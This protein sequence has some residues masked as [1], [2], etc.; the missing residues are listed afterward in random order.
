MVRRV[1]QPIDTFVVVATLKTIGLRTKTTVADLHTELSGM[2]P[3][4]ALEALRTLLTDVR[5][6]GIDRDA[7]KRFVPLFS[8]VVQRALTRWLDDD[9]DVA[10]VALCEQYLSIA[11]LHA[12][13]GSSADG[14]TDVDVCLRKIAAGS[15]IVGDFD[16][17]DSD[18]MLL[19][20]SRLAMFAAHEGWGDQIA[21]GQALVPLLCASHRR[22]KFDQL[23]RAETGIGLEEA[24]SMTALFATLGGRNIV[25]N[26]LVSWPTKPEA[27]GYSAETLIAGK[28]LWSQTIDE[29]VDRAITDLRTPGF[30]FT[31]FTTRPLVVDGDD[32]LAVWPRAFSEK[33]FPFGLLTL[34]ER[35]CVAQGLARSAV[36]EECGIVLEERVAQLLGGPAPAYPHLDHVVDEAEQ[37]RRYSNRGRFKPK[38]C[39]WLLIED[40]YVV[41]LE[42]R[43]RPVSLK[44]QATG[45]RADLEHDIEEAILRKLEQCDHALT[46][47]TFDGLMTGRRPVAIVVNSCPLP[48]TPLLVDYIEHS[49][50]PDRF[51][52][53]AE[54]KYTWAVVELSE[55]RQLLRGGRAKG[56]SVGKITCRWRT[57]PLMD[58]MSFYDWATQKLH[59]ATRN[60]GTEWIDVAARRV[61]GVDLHAAMLLRQAP[62]REQKRK[63][64]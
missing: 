23:C 16:G 46:N 4:A 54:H 2:H 51:P 33:A 19:Q 42:A 63:R 27:G 3:R 5:D 38:R 21:E 25:S 18:D 41:A 53:Y 43:N 59:R 9:D 1:R 10:R 8:G 64:R 58:N 14:D 24:W 28:K 29:C 60:P 52:H 61:F 48:V 31:A 11:G 47:A 20:I 56:L 37:K 62:K 6:A 34:V 7:H 12:V 49:L 35:V 45:L 30:A 15:L 17:V 39:D 55:L 57:D 26:G 22:I 44:S 50:V 36:R 40:E 13:A 32:Q